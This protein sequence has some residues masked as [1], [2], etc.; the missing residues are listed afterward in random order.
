MVMYSF[1]TLVNDFAR[2]ERMVQS[3][4]RLGSDAGDWEFLYIDNTVAN[5]ADGFSGY[6]SLLRTACGRYV[7]L[8]HRISLALMMTA[9][10]LT[11]CYLSFLIRNRI[12][13]YAGIQAWMARGGASSGYRPLFLR[14][15]CRRPL[16]SPCR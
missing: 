9:K 4:R 14:P 11:A 13:G 16:P 12:G 15:I 1:C 5:H 10:L 6:N 3:F 8:C 2:Y 7:I